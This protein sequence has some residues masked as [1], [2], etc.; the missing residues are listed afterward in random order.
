MGEKLE[1]ELD[2]A[3][4]KRKREGGWQGVRKGEEE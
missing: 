4:E 3:V 1:A 2:I